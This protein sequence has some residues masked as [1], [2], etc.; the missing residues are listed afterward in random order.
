MIEQYV[1]LWR[2]KSTFNDK[3]ISLE[4]VLKIPLTSLIFSAHKCLFFILLWDVAV[5]NKSFHDR[6]K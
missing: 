1:I 3:K 5:Y 6:L 2:L 4:I